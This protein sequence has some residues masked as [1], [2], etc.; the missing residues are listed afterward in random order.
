MLYGALMIRTPVFAVLATLFLCGCPP[1]MYGFY[2]AS[3]PTMA[4]VGFD[5]I[6]ERLRAI[7]G[8]ENV[9]YRTETGGRPLTWSGIKPAIIVHRYSFNIDGEDLN[10]Y[11]EEYWDGKISYHGGAATTQ[12]DKGPALIQLSKPVFQQIETEIQ[13]CGYED[14]TG[15]TYGDRF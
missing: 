7:P 2:R 9:S 8:V 15:I 14:L 4:V 3:N 12:R 1:K 6:E 10:F 11:L 13:Q 5:C